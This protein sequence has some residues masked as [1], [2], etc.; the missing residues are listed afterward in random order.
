MPQVETEGATD[1][2]PEGA[3][4]IG[5]KGATYVRPESATD[6]VVT[7]RE[8]EGRV[9][10]ISQKVFIRS[11]GRSQFPHKSVNLSF[12]ITDVKHKLTDLRGHRL[13]QNDF[14]TTLCEIR[15]AA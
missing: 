10:C 3:T 15:P 13:L 8:A 7:I 2:E 12:I 11:F 9:S 1:I 14:V 5:T 6:Q 4:N